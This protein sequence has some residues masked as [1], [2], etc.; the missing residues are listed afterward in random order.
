MPEGFFLGSTLAQ[1]KPPPSL[2]AKCGACG[3]Y[4]DCQSPK[5]PPSG[6]GKRKILVVG[7]FPGEEEDRRGSHLV[8]KANQHFRGLLRK[9]G[10]DPDK[11][12]VHTNALICRTDGDKPPTTKQIGYCRPNLLKTLQQ[13]KPTT[14]LLLGAAAVESVVGWAWKENVGAIERWVGWNIPHQR[15]NT[16]LCPIYHPS[17]LMKEDSKALNVIFDRHLKAALSHEGVPW[18]DGAP[19]YRK[20][21]EIILSPTKAAKAIRSITKQGDPSAFDYET[22]RLKPE[23]RDSQIVCCSISNGKRTIAYPWNGDAITATREFIR[24]PIAKIA[25]NMKFE[26]RWTRRLL[27]TRV[28]NWMWCTMTG[29]HVLDHRQSVTSVK[30]QSLVQLGFEAYD[31]HIGTFLQ[32]KGGQGMNKILSEIDI[33]DLLLYCGVDSLVEWHVAKLQMKQIGKPFR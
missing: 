8:G 26:E 12:C 25:S 28:K 17:F 3:L 31:D 27:K 14:I 16:W 18:P 29:A 32:G 11:D 24:S 7:S 21:V 23:R 33:S 30:F 20:E 22:N 2:V 15:L 5:M 1:S 10:V 9:H 4:K 13:A 19:N 6:K